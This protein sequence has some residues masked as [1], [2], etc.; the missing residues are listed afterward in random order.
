M[1]GPQQGSSTILEFSKMNLKLLRSDLKP[2]LT[3]HS[4]SLEPYSFKHETNSSMDFS[5]K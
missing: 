1:E 2:L 5:E 4:D 3:T